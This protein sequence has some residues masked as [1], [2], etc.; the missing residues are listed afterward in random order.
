V[1]SQV[2]PLDLLPMARFPKRSVD[3]FAIVAMPTV[4]PQKNGA[5]EE[6]YSISSR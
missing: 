2:K 4:D 5:S 6:P 3:G 1:K